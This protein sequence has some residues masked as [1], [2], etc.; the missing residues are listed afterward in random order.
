M[1]IDRPQQRLA[2]QLAAGQFHHGNTAWSSQASL[3]A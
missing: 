1:Q 2:S 3:T